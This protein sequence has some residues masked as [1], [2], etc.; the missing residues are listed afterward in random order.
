MSPEPVEA[1]VVGV[2]L[3]HSLHDLLLN[4]PVTTSEAAF[5]LHKAAGRGLVSV[6]RPPFTLSSTRTTAAAKVS[7]YM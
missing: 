2:V 7:P 5:R 6:T 1:R 4:R 3:S